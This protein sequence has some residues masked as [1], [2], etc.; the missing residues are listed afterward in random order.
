MHVPCR[1]KN[2][3][4]KEF[5]TISLFFGENVPYYMEETW[6][7]NSKKSLNYLPKRGYNMIWAIHL[8]SQE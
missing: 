7:R 3:S 1:R 2:P 8:N 5:S 6:R 4:N